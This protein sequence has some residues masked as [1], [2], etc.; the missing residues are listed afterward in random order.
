[1]K[2]NTG[3]VLIPMSVCL[4]L[5]RDKVIEFPLSKC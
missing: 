2:I 1:M 3:L 4:E 5:F